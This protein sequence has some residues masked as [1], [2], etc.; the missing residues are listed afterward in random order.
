MEKKK[1]YQKITLHDHLTHLKECYLVLGLGFLSWISE[2]PIVIKALKKGYKKYNMSL[3]LLLWN[4]LIKYHL[5]GFTPQEYFEYKL[6][7]NDYKNFVPIFEVVNCSRINRFNVDLLINKYNFKKRLIENNIS[8]ARFIAYYNHKEKKIYNYEK[9][10]SDKVV[11]KPNRGGGGEGV[12]I[13]KYDEYENFL[14]KMDKNYI[15]E[16]YIKQH[17]FLNK[18]FDG[19]VNSIR[20]LT[21]KK[22]DKFIILKIILRTGRKTT[23]CVDNFSQGG[24]SI[25]IDL[26]KG[27]LKKGKTHFKYGDEE[28]EYHPDTGFKFFGEKLPF[29]NEVKKIAIDAHMCFPMFIIIGWDIAITEHGP[30][31]IEGNRTPGF[32]VF[33]IHEGLKSKLLDTQF[34][35]KDKK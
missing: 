11:A 1:E 22:D 26:E 4:A 32:C 18:I 5:L 8:T 29:Y 21:I 20:V 16:D 23:D 25:D 35:K 31:I 14:K 3:L 15:V 17:S 30:I 34:Y 12:K 33:Q 9:P 7:K 13:L 6:Y 28:Y 24:I 10:S 27:T 2:A 19:S